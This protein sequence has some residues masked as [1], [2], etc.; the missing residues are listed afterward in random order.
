M[1]PLPPGD[2]TAAFSGGELPGGLNG[3]LNGRA[4]DRPVAGG[5]PW[6]AIVANRSSGSGGNNLLVRR[7][8]SKLAKLGFATEVAWTPS[9][10]TK[11]VAETESRPGCRCLVAVGGDG[12][13]S[14][15]IN[16]QPKIPVTVLPAGTENLAARHFGLRRNT[17]RPG[18]EH[19]RG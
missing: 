8:I 3:H 19:R 9:E 16:E 10:R 4:V 6:V 18:P 17:G 5:E 12:T 13:V 1:K 7:L 14:A 2:I 11:L 15:L